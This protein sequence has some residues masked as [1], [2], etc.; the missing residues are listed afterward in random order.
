MWIQLNGATSTLIKS[1]EGIEDK[2][3][4]HI[5][6]HSFASVIFKGALSKDI[7]SKIMPKT[8]KIHQHPQYYSQDPG[9]RFS[10]VPRTFRAQKA[11]HKTATCLFCRAGLFICC[12]RNKNNNKC[13]VLCLKLLCF[14]DKKRIMSPDLCLKSFGTFEK[15]APD[16]LWILISYHVTPYYYIDP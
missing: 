12:N 10:K 1:K 14:E 2:V 7:F 15:Q 6:P 3:S 8:N 9:A 11:I 4:Q 16:S 13:K 5:F